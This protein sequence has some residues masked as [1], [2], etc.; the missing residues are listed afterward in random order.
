MTPK[1][2]YIDGWLGWMG[3]DGWDGWMDGTEVKMSPPNLFTLCGY[4]IH[5]YM[6]LYTCS[7]FVTNF[8]MGLKI[9]SQVGVLASH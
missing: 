7:N 2:F 3:W 6:N 5:V 8:V 9:L 1:I 4:T